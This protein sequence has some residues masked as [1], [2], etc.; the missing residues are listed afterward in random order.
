MKLKKG[1][2]FGI[3]AGVLISLIAIFLFRGEKIFWFLLILALIIIVLPFVISFILVQ[4]EQKEKEKKFLEFTRDLVENVK[5]G[6]PISKSIIN[7]RKRNYGP[8]SAHVEKLANQISLGIPLTIAFLTFAKETKSSVISRAV[9]LISEAEKAGGEIGTILESVASSVNQIEIL[10]K[11]RKSAVSNLVVQGYIIF[12]VFIIIML[13][14][15]FKI[16]PMTAGLVDVQDLNIKISTITTESFSLPLLAMILVQS[17]FA[18][19]VIG[20]ISE[21]SLKYG[22]KHS[23][24]LLA[25]TLLITTGA[26]IFLG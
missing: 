17:F 13:V 5:S 20:K 4:G 23:F 11:E 24:I 9:G 22:I 10:R 14:L 26:K 8:L 25:V 3:I 18:G 6:T 15:E 7:L 19:L 16:L 2:L 1:H 12:F 21:G